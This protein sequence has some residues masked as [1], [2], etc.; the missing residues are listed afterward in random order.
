MKVHFKD[1]LVKEGEE[2]FVGTPIWPME[3]DD[4]MKFQTITMSAKRNVKTVKN[5]IKIFRL[6]YIPLKM[7][8]L[9]LLVP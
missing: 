8:K 9:N 4:N 5:L 1:I 6:H 3:V 7:T 2:V